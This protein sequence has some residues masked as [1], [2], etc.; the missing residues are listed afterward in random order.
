MAIAISSV[1]GTWPTVGLLATLG[2]AGVQAQEVVDLSAEDLP[3]AVNLE[4][5]YRIGSAMARSEW[6][7]FTAVQYIGFDRTGNLYIL[8]APGPEAGT[9]VVIVDPAGRHV[10][11]F[12]R[13]GEGPGESSGRA[14]VVWADGR[15]HRGVLH[16]GRSHCSAGRFQ[17]H[18]EGAVGPNCGRPV[19]AGTV[20]AWSWG[21]VR[22]RAG[23]L[24]RSTVVGEVS[25]RTVVEALGAAA[26]G[27]G[28]RCPCDPGGFRR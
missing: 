9:R 24:I 3:L 19:D 20:W 1:Y 14:L 10:K 18:G 5:V 22:T 16:H 4:P 28:P 8:D 2:T 11:D 27:R 17:T 15:A 26:V 13:Q 12:G 23:A 7:Q 21:P 25:E 6:E